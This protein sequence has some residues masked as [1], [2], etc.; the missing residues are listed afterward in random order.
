VSKGGI[1]LTTDTPTRWA[2]TQSPAVEVFYHS[3]HGGMDANGVSYAPLGATWGG[4]TW[5]NSTQMTLA[6]QSLR[7]A[8]WSTCLSLRVH[9]GQDPWRT[10][11]T[12]TNGVRMIFGWE[13][14]SWDDP[15]YGANFWKHWNAEKKFSRTWL[16]A[17][18]DAGHDQA[19]SAAARGAS[20]AEAQDRV[21]NEGYFSS[22]PAASN[23][24]WWVWWDAARSVGAPVTALQAPSAEAYLLELG[25]LGGRRRAALESVGETTMVGD[26]HAHIKLAP[27][28]GTE[29]LATAASQATIMA[30]AD[31]V[32]SALTLDGIELTPAHTRVLRTAGA[33]KDERTKDSVAGYAVEYRQ[34]VDSV[35]VISPGA[36]YL[37]VSLDAHGA[38]TS[39]TL[40]A[41]PVKAKVARPVRT[42]PQPGSGVG[43]P[44]DAAAIGDE[45]G[46]RLDAAGSAAL[47]AQPLADTRQ[48]GYVVEGARAHLAA[49]QG[50]LLDFGQ[51]ILKKVRVTTWGDAGFAYITPAYLNA[52]FFPEGYGMIAA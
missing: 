20:A 49:S 16:Q 31:G 30:A 18:W 27:D 2:V 15:G 19:P 50:T 24:M 11:S 38:P 51:G 44:M 1:V 47:S 40:T 22:A 35:P 17:G 45:L 32:R 3:G 33:S 36:G 10:W 25:T 46:V 41:R 6:N 34:T 9:D 43:G 23:W 42:T 52:A 7:Y 12:H 14:V 21:F 13:S 29:H 48:I 5:V 26:G 28:A 37:R 39:A 4:Q 8:F